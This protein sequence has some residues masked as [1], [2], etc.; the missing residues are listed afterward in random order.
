M[1][2]LVLG[3]AGNRIFNCTVDLFV[4]GVIVSPTGCHI[5]LP[6]QCLYT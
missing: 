3:V 6:Y 4:D 1:R 2:I 5:V